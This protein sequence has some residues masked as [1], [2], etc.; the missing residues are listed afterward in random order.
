MIELVGCFIENNMKVLK[1]N[2]KNNKVIISFKSSD[3]LF[4][5]DLVSISPRSNI[6]V[7]K[8]I[9]V[10]ADE[11]EIYY[12]AEFSSN[13]YSF[14]DNYMKKYN[15]SYYDFI[16]CSIS[17]VT[18]KIDKVFV[19]TDSFKPVSNSYLRELK[20]E[21]SVDNISSVS[22]PSIYAD[23]LKDFVNTFVN[24]PDTVIVLVTKSK[25]FIDYFYSNCKKQ[26]E[27]NIRIADI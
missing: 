26:F 27:K 23:G 24:K 22:V 9:S 7:F 11:N 8:I 6:A 15:L 18:E 2:L 10:S 21:Y 13:C 25:K 4:I 3:S 14:L 16:G 5:G 12:E 19:I 1:L 17:K 20:R